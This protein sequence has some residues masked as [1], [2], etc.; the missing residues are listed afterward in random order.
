[1]A[2]FRSIT[3]LPSAFKLST[4]SLLSIFTWIPSAS[5][6]F[7]IPRCCMLAVRDEFQRYYNPLEIRY[8]WQICN[9]NIDINYSSN[10][11]FSSVTAPISWA[12]QF[13]HGTQLSDTHQWLQPLAAYISPYMG[14]VLLC[15]IGET[16]QDEDT[17]DKPWK[18]FFLSALDTLKE[19]ISILGDPASAIAGAASEIYADT[20]AL[21]NISSLCERDAQHAR[22]VAALAGSLK[23]SSET[24]WLRPFISTPQS[25]ES[26]GLLSKG[27]V[28]TP[29]I[30]PVIGG[31]YQ[32][33]SPTDPNPE[34][35]S[36]AISICIAARA[37]FA[38]TILIPVALMLAVTAATF[39]D[40][41]ANKGDKDT[42]LALAYCIWYSWILVPA[43]V[44]NCFATVISPD[45]ARTAFSKVMCFGEGKGVIMALRDRHVN[46]QFWG[47]WLKPQE[48]IDGGRK[49]LEEFKEELSGNMWFWAR[50]C[51]WTLLGWSVVA[52]A[53]GA[54]AVIAWTTPTVGL[55]CRSMNIILY[56]VLALV[57]GFLHVLYSWLVVRESTK[58]FKKARLTPVGMVKAV[59][60]GLVVVNAVVVMA[61]GTIFHLVGVYRTCWCARM[62]WKGDVMIEL[63]GKTDEAVQNANR[64]WL[65]TS[66]VVFSIMTLICLL[67]IVFRQI[68][69][70]RMDEW[71]G[72]DER[73]E[74]GN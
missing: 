68:I 10:E 39:Y 50:F 6:T 4:L 31:E 59:Y 65:S 73:D 3:A 48:R 30:T 26:Q 49:G 71:M 72:K 8:P 17:K 14:L 35:T 22:W 74:K 29:T 64:Y 23:F 52:V 33:H 41:Y 36:R 15:P 45:L 56:G 28:R 66:Y 16:E 70:W 46:N 1:M 40:A 34:E 61:L 60:W 53:C 27:G 20:V 24:D 38:S 63:N 12:K 69:S 54:G 55:G 2:S 19:F 7:S 67:G 32:P 25:P 62:T 5:A 13:C 11:T 37:S 42:A 9:F 21:W 47:N 57:N 43:V 44:G 58:G 51:G 18:S